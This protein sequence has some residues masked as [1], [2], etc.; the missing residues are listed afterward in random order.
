MEAT[1]LQPLHIIKTKANSPQ[2]GQAT[3]TILQ[4]LHRIETVV[5]SHQ[6]GQA[7]ERITDHNE[8]AANAG[9]LHPLNQAGVYIYICIAIIVL[10]GKKLQNS[11]EIQ[12]KWKDFDI[13]ISFFQF[14]I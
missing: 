6:T 9:I 3:E 8:P 7:T 11:E 4:P 2:T 1:I 13:L 12:L 14:F 10:K 5:N